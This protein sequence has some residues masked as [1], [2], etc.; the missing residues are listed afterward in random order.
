[1]PMPRISDRRA[2]APAFT[3]VEI[4]VVIGIVAIL[5]A[6]LFPALSKARRKALILACPIAFVGDD[7]ALYLVSPNG[8]AELR[9][10]EPGWQV[11]SR[12][13][14]SSPVAWSTCGRRIGFD[15][16]ERD[17]GREYTVFMDPLNGHV[18]KH[19][20]AR[21]GGWVDYD[22]WLERGAYFPHHP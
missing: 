16:R 6:L 1:M 7:G 3:L 12:G 22:R 2:A 11:Q 10:S 19:S 5:I 14:L 8:S 13:G 17:T 18:W 21:F 4:L 20:G 15:M 9:L